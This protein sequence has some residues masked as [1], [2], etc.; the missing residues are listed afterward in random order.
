MPFVTEAAFR[1]D[2]VVS[3]SITGKQVELKP[4]MAI[5]PESTSPSDTS[6]FA[7]TSYPEALQGPSSG[8]ILG[9]EPT[10]PTCSTTIPDAASALAAFAVGNTPEG[11]NSDS[12]KPCV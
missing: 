6:W 4:M 5:F 10:S 1:K 11:R 2:F 9:H 3:A 7:T 8:V 12:G